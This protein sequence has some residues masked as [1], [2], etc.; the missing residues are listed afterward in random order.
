M[1]MYPTLMEAAGAPLSEHALSILLGSY[2][3]FG[4]LNGTLGGIGVIGT[5]AA[6]A[7][8]ETWAHATEGTMNQGVLDTNMRK[9]KENIKDWKLLKRYADDGS[10]LAAYKEAVLSRHEAED[11]RRVKVEELKAVCEKPTRTKQTM[12]TYQ[13][14]DTRGQIGLAY[15]EKQGRIAEQ[16]VNLGRHRDF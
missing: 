5:T 15:V 11:E 3:E 1:L 13:L 10:E 6:R 8:P 16:K 12:L 7:P 2:A 9:S 14:D 4:G